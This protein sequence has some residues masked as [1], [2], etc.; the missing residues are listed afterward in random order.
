[1]WGKGAGPQAS[2]AMLMTPFATLG[3]LPLSLVRLRPKKRLYK[4]SWWYLHNKVLAQL[5]CTFLDSNHYEVIYCVSTAWNKLHIR[6]LLAGWLASEGHTW[7]GPS[8]RAVLN[9][10]QILPQSS[11]WLAFSTEILHWQHVCMQCSIFLNVVLGKK[12]LDKINDRHKASKA[13]Q[14]LQSMRW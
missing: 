1:M 12:K 5:S 7:R 14:W 4:I 8:M 3:P 11:E 2:T 13:K 9:F 6:G 10:Q